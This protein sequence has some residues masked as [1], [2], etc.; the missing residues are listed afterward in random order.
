MPT[1]C[2]EHSQF[3]AAHIYQRRI[4]L[5]TPSGQS[6]LYTPTLRARVMIGVMLVALAICS[7]YAQAQSG[8]DT[9]KRAQ[10]SGTQQG[11]AQSTGAGKST[12]G[13]ASKSAAAKNK[14]RDFKP[15]ERI[16]AGTAVPF[17]VDI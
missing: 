14:K 13:D 9:A 1:R 5:R 7:V 10:T 8:A 4:V 17:P 12:K 2:R 6:P 15:S 3:S 11:G 16:G